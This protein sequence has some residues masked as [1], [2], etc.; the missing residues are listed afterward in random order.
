MKNMMIFIGL[1]Q[2]HPVFKDL[3]SKLNHWVANYRS[4]R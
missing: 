3:Q 1:G 2:G 4:V